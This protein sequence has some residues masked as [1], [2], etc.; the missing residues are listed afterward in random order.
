MGQR[1]EEWYELVR[2]SVTTDAINW[3]QAELGIS[4][5]F[6]HKLDAE[7][8]I[9]VKGNR[10]AV[11]LF[12]REESP[13]EPEW[14]VPELLYEDDFCLVAS[15]PAGMAV[16]PS[17]PEQIGTLANA[18]AGYYQMTGQT[19]RVRHIHRLDED[20]TG[21]VLYAKNELAQLRL[22]EDMREKAIGR[23]YLAL[24]HG[25][26]GSKNGT[27]D[28]PI[29]RDRHQSGRR[30]VSPTGEQAIT[31]YEQVEVFNGYS[32]V[33]LHLSTGRTHQIRVHMSHLGHPLVGDKLYGGKQEIV[34]AK[35][36]GAAMGSTLAVTRQ[37]LHGEQLEF[38]HPL[39]R[40]RIHLF[41]PLP[42]DMAGWLEQL[43]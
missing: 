42:D 12:P 2:A 28:A 23:I 8:G 4:T 31:H 1:K 38:L 14:N 40:E 25:K 20:T 10:I 35:S 26:L 21:P 9:R 27:I 3:L 34:I 24:I 39:T 43:R 32:L 18:L 17:R 37:A 5:K 19:C 15:K 13:F 11:R 30:R 6:L 7:N 29:G 36:T 16:H 33:R 41:A 22:D